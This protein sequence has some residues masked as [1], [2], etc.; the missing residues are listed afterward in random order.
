[1]LGTVH[2]SHTE[3]RIY[4]WCAKKNKGPFIPPDSNIWNHFETLGHLGELGTLVWCSGI[5]VFVCVGG[6]R[7]HTDHAEAVATLPATLCDK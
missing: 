2:S 3:T 7:R 4:R 6:G 5:E 1:M